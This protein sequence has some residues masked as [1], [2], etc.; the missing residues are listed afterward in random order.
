M[1]LKNTIERR[2]K[3]HSLQRTDDPLSGQTPGNIAY[4]I[5]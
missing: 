2:Q 3:I 4:T 1:L 5:L